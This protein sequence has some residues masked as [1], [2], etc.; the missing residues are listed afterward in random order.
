MSVVTHL[1]FKIVEENNYMFRPFSGWAIIR[2]RISEKTHIVQCGH[3][4]KRGFPHSWCPCCSIWVFSDILV[5][6]WWWPTQK[7]AETCSFL[8]QFENTVVLRRTFIHLISTS[9]ESHNGWCHQR[10]DTCYSTTLQL[11]TKTE[12]RLSLPRA[13]FCYGFWNL[14]CCVEFVCMCVCMNGVQ[15]TLPRS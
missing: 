13:R 7:R 11:S 5:S 4:S 10:P 15:Y 3:C 2:L 14:N 12:G 9:T 1:Y 6:T 8:Q